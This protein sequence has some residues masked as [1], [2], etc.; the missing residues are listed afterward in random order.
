[1]QTSEAPKRTPLVVL[2]PDKPEN[3]AILLAFGENLRSLRT[4]AGLSQRRLARRCFLRH[5]DISGL[6]RGVRSPGL[7]V[8]LML[9]HAIGVSVGELTEGLPAPTR[10]VGR[11]QTLALIAAQPSIG[12]RELTESLALPEWYVGKR[13]RC[14]EASRE[15]VHEQDG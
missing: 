1:V 11:A 12:M 15:I 9:A 6:E 2:R 4:A 5:D 8:L 13:L 7:Q 3:D 10:Q 14:L